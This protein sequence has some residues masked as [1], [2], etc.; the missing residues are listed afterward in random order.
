MSGLAHYFEDEGVPTVVVALIREQAEKLRPPRALWVPFPLGRPFGAPNHADRQR[1]VLRRALALLEAPLGPVLVDFDETG[2]ENEVEDAAWVCPVRF[3]PP[4]VADTGIARRLADELTLLRPWYELGVER[5]GRTT[6]GLAKAPV[7]AAAAWLAAF[8]EG[9][10]A[11]PPAPG[12]SIP[13]NLRWAAEDLKA[14][15]HEAAS[16][17]PGPAPGARL[18]S[19]F[20][21]ESTAGELLNALCRRCL[22]D[23]DETVREVGEITLV[24]EDCR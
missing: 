4:P 16:A 5:R 12:E 20:W 1:R 18:E 6:L 21:K 24:P 22:A 13:D 17:Q 14:F 8:A 10:T 9:R 11:P 7:E 3:A 2:P 19:W 23:D 15:Y